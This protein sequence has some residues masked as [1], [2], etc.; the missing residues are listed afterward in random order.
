MKYKYIYHLKTRR[1]G[2][3]SE[4]IS[5][6]M[7]QKLNAR[8]CKVSRQ[9]G[10]KDTGRPPTLQGAWLHK[11]EGQSDKIMHGLLESEEKKYNAMVEKNIM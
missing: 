8:L 6:A 5:E 2:E 1:K 9:Q 7:T 4:Q 10:K 11:G 3:I